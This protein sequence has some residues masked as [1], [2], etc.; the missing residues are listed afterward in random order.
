[1]R[2]RQMR[3]ISLSGSTDFYTNYIREIVYVFP[4]HLFFQ[5]L[6]KRL[7]MMRI[8]QENK[9]CEGAID[10]HEV[11]R[12]ILLAERVKSHHAFRK[13]G[14]RNNFTFVKGSQTF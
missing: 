3:Y 14:K 10:T 2:V 11:N 4:P 5:G 6:M 7:Q 1:M 13:R 9:E 12:W 8:G